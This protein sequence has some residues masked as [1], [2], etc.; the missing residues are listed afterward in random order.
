[1]KNKTFTQFAIASWAF[2]FLTEAFGGTEGTLS[3]IIGVLL[4]VSTIGSYLLLY[5]VDSTGKD[6]S[7]K[8]LVLLSAVPVGYFLIDSFFS[9][10]YSYVVAT[11]EV[12]TCGLVIMI[13]MPF[14]WYRLYKS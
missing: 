4:L 5:K 8:A 12:T 1:M 3:T 14:I 11:S 9:G 2:Y 13:S 6:I 7:N 10:M